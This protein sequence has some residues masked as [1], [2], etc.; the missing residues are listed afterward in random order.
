MTQ[1]LLYSLSGAEERK[2]IMNQS[3][4]FRWPAVPGPWKKISPAFWLAFLT[5]GVGGFI[6]HLY[7]FTNLLPNHDSIGGLFTY[8]DMLD[9]GRWASIPMSLPS[10]FFQLPVV[11]GLLS[12]LALGAAAG[13]TVR[14][15]EISH[16]V[17]IVLTSA[18]M[19]TYPAACAIFAYLFTADAYFMALFL[20]ALAVWCTKKYRWGWAAAILMMTWACGTYQA[21]ICYAIGLFLID[22]ILALLKGEEVPG[23]VVRGLKYIGICLAS[24]ALY[25]V[26]LKIVLTVTGTELADYQGLSGL[27]LTSLAEYFSRIP[28]VYQIFFDYLLTPSFLDSFFCV[29]LQAGFVYAAAALVVLAVMN[30]LLRD[31]LRLLLT[32]AGAALL[33]LALNFVALLAAGGE[34]HHLMIYA[35]VLVFVLGIKL[36]ELI[37]ARLISAGRPGWTGVFWPNLVLCAALVWCGFCT[38]N[39]AYL[40]MELRYENSL[41]LANRIAARAENLAGYTPDA[42]IAVVGRLPIDLYGQTLPEL[43]EYD[44]ITGTDGF[45]LQCYY[46]GRDVLEYCIGL[47]MSQSTAEQWDDLYK[48]GILYQTPNWP[49][50]NCMFMFEGMVVVKLSDVYIE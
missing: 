2:G 8:N 23:V 29:V 19:V 36:T 48:S 35:F 24:L 31:P 21:F 22:C 17:H 20:N 14:V 38:D 9:I 13:L 50:P 25:Y 26:V 4:V 49:D 18:L 6:T 10:T 33:P 45:L 28:E 46:S 34:V 41:A 11:I 7:I 32:A 40:R 5:A 12:V 15:L 43:S 30:G 16:P 47:P 27:G 1:A 37:M 42:P 39:I 3:A 44:A